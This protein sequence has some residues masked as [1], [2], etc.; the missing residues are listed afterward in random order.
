MKEF[1]TSIQE[2]AEICEA[3]KKIVGQEAADLIEKLILWEM[4][5]HERNYSHE[6]S[7][8]WD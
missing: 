4:M 6:S 1:K 2:R 7:G 8:Y 3:L 5:E